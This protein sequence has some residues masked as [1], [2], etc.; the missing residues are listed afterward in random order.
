MLSRKEQSRPGRPL[1]EQ[2]HGELREA[3]AN[4]YGDRAKGEGKAF[5]V[6]GFTYPDELFLAVSYSGPEGD[7]AAPTTYMA[8]A[9]LGDG[10]AAK[11]NPKTL[12]D[13]LIDS[14]GLFFE[15]F[16]GHPREDFYRGTWCESEMRGHTFYYRVTR[17]NVAL[18][19]RADELLGE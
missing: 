2:W 11:E 6:H 3:L 19:L 9:D 7:S 13:V 16:F 17:E 1:P 12:F 14:V 4:L 10:E 18:T 15:A 8:S 5:Q